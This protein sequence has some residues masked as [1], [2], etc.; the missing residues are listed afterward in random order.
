MT[1][2]PKRRQNLSAICCILLAGLTFVVPSSGPAKAAALSPGQQ[3][4]YRNALKA[5]DNSSYVKG[6]GL[7]QQG[8]N[9]LMS[10]LV[11]WKVML[12]GDSGMTFRDIASF[13][14]GHSHWPGER[15][16]R[17]RAEN[18]LG[19][20][21][22]P[23][24]EALAWFRKWPPVTIDGIVRFA[25]LLDAQGDSE[26]AA[27]LIRNSWVA[28]S[29]DRAEEAAILGPFANI[30]RLEDHERRLDRLLWD[31]HFTEAGR[32]LDRVSPG[33]KAVAEARMSLSRREDKALAV[34]A[35]VPAALQDNPGL[36]YELARW[37][38]RKKDDYENA[39]R[40]LNRAS[41]SA[42]N[43][44]DWGMERGYVTRDALMNGDI[45]LAYK[46]ASQHG[47]KSGLAFA[48]G[49][50]LSGWIM[51]RFLKEP[52][53]GYKHFS[54][55]YRGV[56][57]PISIARGAYWA[58]RS[59][60]AAG[61]KKVAEAWYQAASRHITTYYGQL[62]AEKL[63][64]NVQTH[65]PEPPVPS[66]QARAHF[67]SRDLVQLLRLMDALNYGRHENAFFY[68]LK[69]SLEHPVE[70]QLLAEFARE[71][72]KRPHLALSMAK[73]LL[74]D[75][76]VM[77][78]LLFPT[79]N[80]Q[81][82]NEPELPLV[83]A[84]IRQESAYNVGA[85]SHAGARGLMQLMPGTAKEVARRVGVRYSPSRLVTDPDYNVLLGKSY[86]NGVLDRF[87]GSYILALSSY[88]AGPGR[89][90]QW[91]GMFGDPRDPAIDPVDWV[92]MIPYN[93]T[94]NYVQRIMESLQIYRYRMGEQG[95]KVAALSRD[96][97][98][99]SGV[100]TD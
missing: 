92:E 50:F 42:E 11:R 100:R 72:L 16:L 97:K 3:K 56:N 77:A 99:Q 84:L 73:E 23:D 66:A 96:L 48:E 67:E 58:G 30:L 46:V 82:F 78:D 51:T 26:A 13:L 7:A 33:L 93:E 86:L 75:G 20:E 55:L 68:T 89:T 6:L 43:I 85:V 40:F 28:E 19:K 80:M 52:F 1:S 64:S 62:G 79:I 31:K 69:Q 94:R 8:S 71:T 9:R 18:A 47:A 76:V 45:S 2:R 27:N 81:P 98:R 36:L 41:Q 90:A 24:S 63:G 37:H 29:M 4:L 57:T 53:E 49:E 44:G 70:K 88:N 39:A 83:Y 25:K 95:G 74:R 5:V 59:A 91:I 61:D 34:A 54:S 38:R 22:I 10:D 14:E 15:T 60:E 87:S 17:K 32:M 35:R 21:Q 65:L 12:A